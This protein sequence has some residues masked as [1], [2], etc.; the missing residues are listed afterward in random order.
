MAA[1]EWQRQRTMEAVLIATVSG[2]T[3]AGGTYAVLEHRVASLESIVKTQNVTLNGAVRV[4]DR[5]ELEMGLANEHRSLIGHPG[6]L[7]HMDQVEH[8]L[9]TLAERLRNM[10]LERGRGNGK[11]NV[12]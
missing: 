4:L 3:G 1:P 11:R 8:H 9:K 7:R 2:I 5:I 6:M 10:E 12:P